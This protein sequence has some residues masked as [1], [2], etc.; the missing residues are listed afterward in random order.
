MTIGRIY[1]IR[2]GQTS[3]NG[4]QYVGWDDL[5]LNET[6]IQQAHQIAA[7]LETFPISEIY[8][9]PLMRAIETARPLCESKGLKIMHHD[10]LKEINYG[11]F[12]GRLKSELNL[13]L[14]KQNRY[15][16]LPDG[17]SLN[18]VYQRVRRFKDSIA[19]SLIGYKPIAIIAHFWSIRLFLGVLQ[20]LD[21]ESIFVSGGYKPGNGTIYEITYQYD[22]WGN[23][24]FISKGY[25]NCTTLNSETVL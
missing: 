12:Q 1:L 21:F 7:L 14:R 6:G 25:L 17:E 11:E 15:E 9:S 18:D 20:E 8:S 22:Q 19:S 3:G 5:P 24:D 23:F 10:E 16:P 13:K 2:H 4:N